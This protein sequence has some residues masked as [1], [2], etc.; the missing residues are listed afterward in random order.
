MTLAVIQEAVI[1]IDTSHLSSPDETL[2]RGGG[3]EPPQ[4]FTYD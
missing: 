3:V 4:T 2:G 1:A